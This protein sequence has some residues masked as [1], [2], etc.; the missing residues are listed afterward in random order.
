MEYES[1]SVFEGKYS[2]AIENAESLAKKYQVH[3]NHVS[4]AMI[5][6]QDKVKMLILAATKISQLGPNDNE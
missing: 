2:F 1:K 5:L 6:K 4:I 3:K